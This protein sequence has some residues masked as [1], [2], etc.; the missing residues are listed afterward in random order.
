MSGPIPTQAKTSTMRDLRVRQARRLALRM[1][2]GVVL[3]TL[4][5]A[6]YFGLIATPRF[7]SATSFTIQSSD[8]PTGGG[9]LQML[10]SVVPGSSGRDPLLVQEYLESRDVVEKLVRDDRLRER[11]SGSDIDWFS[12]LSADASLDEVHE[13]FLSR[14]VLVEHDTTSGLVTLRVR[15]FSANDAKELSQALL[16]ASEHV[17]NTLS[18]RAR[19][20]RMRLASEQVASAEQRLSS[21]RE[22]LAR[23]QSEGG[24]LN[25]A[26]SAGAVLE[27]RS[28]LEGE[29]ALARAQ[30][31][32]V[33]G[34]L[35]P[36]APEVIER[37]R[38]VAALQRQID[39]Q[40]AR[41]T[42]ATGG[43]LSGTIARFEPVVVE[44]ELAE[45]LYEGALAALE[46]ARIDAARQHR[47][48]QRIAGPSLPDEPR[49][50][51]VWRDV[52]LVFLASFALLGIG[53]LVIASVREH[54]NV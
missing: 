22:S 16:E 23:L 41:L 20:D 35:Q 54:A 4:L 33:S 11:Y 48:L 38:H 19:S 2:V 17:V 42:G 30:L 21:A 53:T 29:L 31:A 13:Y 51:I 7:E 47:Y 50:P 34:T 15:A 28:R 1:G 5:A 49:Y 26:A 9:A 52:L 6:I 32:T 25:P 43:A 37:R 24:E 3:P 44:K 10:V 45:R 36:T 40:S 39:E 18:E 8:T 27:I 12:R 14:V 46:V